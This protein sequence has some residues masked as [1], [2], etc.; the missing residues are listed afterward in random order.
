MPL[1]QSE[2]IVAFKA[3][4]GLGSVATGS[5]ATQ[6]EVTPS[7]GLN[8]TRTPI[9][10][11]LISASRMRKRSRPGTK[12]INVQYGAELSVGS[13]HEIL[14]A[15]VGAT[16][17]TAEAAYSNLDW[18]D[19]TITGT[20][21]TITFGSGT[22][23]TD[24][25]RAGMFIKFANLSVAGNND[26]YAPIA[27]V[28]SET[29]L[30]I[31]SGFLADNSSDAAWDAV[32]ASHVYTP[33]T[34]VKTYYTFEEYWGSTIDIGKRGLDMVFNSFGLNCQ[35]NQPAQV[36]FGLGG[37]DGDTVSA[38]AAPNFTSPTLVTGDTLLLLDGSIIQEG[39]V[40][41]DFTGINLTLQAPVSMQPMLS[42]N[43]SPD[44]YLGQFTL[45]GDIT[46]TIEDAAEVAR[47]LADTRFDLLLHFAENESDPKDFV[48]FYFGDLGYTGHASPAGGEG[49][50][51]ESMPV[52]GGRDVRGAATGYAATSMLVSTS[53]AP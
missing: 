21:T 9:Q 52:E 18:G 50:A 7:Q 29:V 24:G 27:Q 41:T 22:L 11:Q 10:S 51:I 15:V 12:Q 38:G 30:T 43:L 33:A 17:Y 45:S 53:Y 36:S 6:I 3:Q 48:S 16:G 31:P 5:G 1:D 46:G 19:C 28:N 37:R 2:V 42:T 20:G 23:L 26:V 44:T 32:I 25:V 35:P 34:Y 14:Q 4:A 49:A 13:I 47:F 40:V 8:L 39:A